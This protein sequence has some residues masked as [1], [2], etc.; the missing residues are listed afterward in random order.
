MR[1][2]SLELDSSIHQVASLDRWRH[3]SWAYGVQVDRLAPLDGL[4]VRTRNSCYE[5]MVTS[6]AAGEVLVR[7]GPFFPTFTRAWVSGSSLGGGCLKMRGIYVGFLLKLEHEG[8]TVRTTRVQAVER[9][10]RPAVH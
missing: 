6:P 4:T 7:G 9:T 3:F 5:L 10:A 8:Q 1:S 2:W